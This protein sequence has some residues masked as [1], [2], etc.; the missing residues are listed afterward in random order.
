[1]LDADE[2]HLSIRKQCELIGYNRSN[3]YYNPHPRISTTQ[4][5]KEAV[6]RRLDYWS[7][8]EP[9]WG[10]SKLVPVLANEGLKVSRELCREL[11]RHMGLETIYPKRRKKWGG[12]K[13][14]PRKLPYLLNEL[15]NNGMIWLPNL[16]WAIDITYIPMAGGHMY[17]TALIDWFSRYI[18]GWELSDT[19]D[20]APVLDCVK[21][22]N[23]S[24]GLPSIL[25][26]DQGT[27]FTSND[28]MLYLQEQGIRQSMDGQGR[29]VD[30]VIIER[31]FRSLKIERIYINEYNSPRELRSDISEYVD[32]YNHIRPH[33]SLKDRTP[34]DVY[35]SVF[36][37][38]DAIAQLRSGG[39][40]FEIEILD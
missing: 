6:M 39:G 34:H 13:S 31:W 30:N 11:R 29:W 35:S 3:V 10:I 17:L 37:N 26:S 9:A 1:M 4:E 21:R 8:R 12:Y 40:I 14:N 20:T 19:L 22:A 23:L 38:E 16:V 33:Q 5:F 7:I 28:Y 25:N 15:R 36:R 2:P 32:R 18:L 27:Q 24:H